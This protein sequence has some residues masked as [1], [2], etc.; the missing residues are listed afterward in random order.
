MI[1]SES[2]VEN[3]YAIEKIELQ[4]TSNIL[5]LPLNDLGNSL[6]EVYYN[7]SHLYLRTLIIDFMNEAGLEWM[8]KLLARDTS[9]IEE[10]GVAVRSVYDF[11]SLVAANDDLMP[12][13]ID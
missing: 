7:T 3:L 2:M 9:P 1:L 13:A 11:T 8:H 5:D 6:I 4:L 10:S 12:I